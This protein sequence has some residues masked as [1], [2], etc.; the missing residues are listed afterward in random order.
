V[1]PGRAGVT[2]ILGVETAHIL[3]EHAPDAERGRDDD[4]G[5]VR[6]AAPEK[7]G[8][9]AHGIAPREAGDDHDRGR[10]EAARHG[11][12]LDP[13]RHGAEKRPARRDDVVN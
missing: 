10:L 1:S 5:Q 11:G 8:R 2:R 7:R 4:R 9:A 3:D 13:E 6:P 12:G